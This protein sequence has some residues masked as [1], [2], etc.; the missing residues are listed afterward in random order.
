MTS[1]LMVDYCEELLIIINLVFVDKN[2]FL[3]LEILSKYSDGNHASPIQ[4]L[5]CFG[6]GLLTGN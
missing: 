6:E 1:L 4:P 5:I 2:T 3:D